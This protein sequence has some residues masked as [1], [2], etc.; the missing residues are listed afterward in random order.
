[1]FLTLDKFR[2]RVR[3]LG[4]K[5]Y[6]GH[7]CIAPFISMEGNLPPDESYKGLPEKVEGP[8]FGLHDFFVGRD[9]YLWLER[10]VKLPEAK[11][12]CE[13]VGLFDFGETGGGYNSGF[14]S[15]LY[16]DGHPY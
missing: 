12:G 1:M 13:T 16:V 3:E 7:S 8:A 10:T 15:L 11:E 5:R 4:E 9:R 2:Q 14:E 6:F